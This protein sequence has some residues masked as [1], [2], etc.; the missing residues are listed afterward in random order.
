MCLI[1]PCPL[2]RRQELIAFSLNAIEGPTE[3]SLD[4]IIRGLPS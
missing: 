4:A 1:A 3:S 2:S